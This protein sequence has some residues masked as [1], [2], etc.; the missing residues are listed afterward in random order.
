MPSVSTVV[1]GRRPADNSQNWSSSKI[2]YSGVNAGPFSGQ[3]VTAAFDGKTSGVQDGA[4]AGRGAFGQHKVKA[5]NSLNLITNPHW[6]WCKGICSVCYLEAT[7]VTSKLTVY[8]T[9]L[10]L[11]KIGMM[12]VWLTLLLIQSKLTQ[13][14]SLELR[15]GQ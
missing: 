14:Q 5:Q 7:L 11:S 10:Q 12:Q 15:F 8:Y 3:P 6:N 9:L 4:N 13:H 1:S 2:T